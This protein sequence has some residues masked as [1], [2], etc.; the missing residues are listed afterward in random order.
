MDVIDKISVYPNPVKNF[1]IINLNQQSDIQTLELYNTNG[2][3]VKSVS[4]EKSETVNLDMSNL[5]TGVY[6]LYA[7]NKVVLSKL[8]KE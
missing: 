6:I 1:C 4:V 2:T 5:E 3:K 8:I 7:D